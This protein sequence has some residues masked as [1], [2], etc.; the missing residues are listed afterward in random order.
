LLLPALLLVVGPATGEGFVELR[1]E[2]VTSDIFPRPT[3][4]VATGPVS[5]LPFYLSVGYRCPAGTDRRILFSS[6]ADSA[7]Q[8]E[9]GPDQPSPV[10]VRVEVSMRQIPWLA[11]P[12]AA[13]AGMKRRPDDVGNSGTRY[14]RLHAAAAGFV[15]LAC[16]GE[17]GLESAADAATAL[18]VWLSCPAAADPAA[19]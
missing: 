3:V 12:A 14:F 11:E 16:H 19:R 9:I 4:G 13:C 5:T 7:Q 18:D 6:I 1:V 8:I 17:S 15:T 2:Q 10:T